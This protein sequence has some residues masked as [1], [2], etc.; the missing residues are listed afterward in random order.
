MVAP[1]NRNDCKLAEPTLE[2][3]RVLPPAVS[4]HLC[5]DRGYDFDGVRTAVEAYCFT[6]PI[7]S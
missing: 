3:R 5:M 2:E 1:A 4:Q 6:H 7:R